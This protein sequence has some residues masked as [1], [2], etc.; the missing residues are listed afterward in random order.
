MT[1]TLLRLSIALL[2]RRERGPPPARLRSPRL[3][4][5]RGLD[6]LGHHVRVSREPVRLLLELAALHLPD[7]DQPAAL[8][9]GRGDLERRYQPAQ[10][11]VVDLLE[12]VLHVLAGDLPVRL[13]L[14]RV[15]DGL[16]VDRRD[17][18]AAVVEDGGGHLL[19]SRLALLL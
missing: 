1:S 11:E 17:E 7:L 19:W 12:A 10:G 8:V 2:R 16:D 14:E 3:L 4:G 9:V 15:A 5:R 18:D 6:V 13:G